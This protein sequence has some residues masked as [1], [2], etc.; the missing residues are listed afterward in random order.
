MPWSLQSTQQAISLPHTER[1]AGRHC[2]S[3]VFQRT[4][5]IK[6]WW[7]FLA[8]R[9]PLP[10]P[11]KTVRAVAES[12]GEVYFYYYIT[13]NLR[14][15]LG[16]FTEVAAKISVWV[17]HLLVPAVPSVHVPCEG[18]KRTT[19]SA[20]IACL[21]EGRETRTDWLAPVWS[22]FY[23]PYSTRQVFI[24]IGASVASPVGGGSSILCREE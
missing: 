12:T 22:F 7:D 14:G 1:Q 10:L 17:L 15:I 16:A 19:F 3:S 23:I 13:R 8:E 2:L 4:G 11:P 20:H 5:R 18:R 6:E 9:H 21:S 24:P